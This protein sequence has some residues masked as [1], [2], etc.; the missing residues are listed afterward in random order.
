MAIL[1]HVAKYFC[2]MKKGFEKFPAKRVKPKNTVSSVSSFKN[3]SHHIAPNNS[4]CQIFGNT[5]RA[6]SKRRTQNLF[7]LDYCQSDEKATG[8]KYY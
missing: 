6:N 4:I 8:V 7:L 1:L 3:A 5:N 2:V